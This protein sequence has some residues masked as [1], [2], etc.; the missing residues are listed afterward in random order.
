PTSED[1]STNI[2]MHPRSKLAPG[3]SY[4][5]S[6]AGL[7]GAGGN[8]PLD[9]PYAL[10][11][12]ARPLLS[13]ASFSPLG[14]D[15]SVDQADLAIDFTTPV[16][17]DAVRKALSSSP[18]IAGLDQGTLSSDGTEYKVTTDLEVTTQYKIRIKSLADRY[19]Q[20]L[21][22]PFEV[23]FKTG[24]AKPRLSMERGIF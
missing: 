10:A 3:A 13:V 12:R 5:L 19:G 6:C 22:A 14:Q 23:S 16:D 9:K 2:A 11:V 21:D 8:A 7:A 15:V 17:L 20:K 24:D 4:T 18:R 1:D